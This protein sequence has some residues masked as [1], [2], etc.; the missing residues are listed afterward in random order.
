MPDEP[1]ARAGLNCSNLLRANPE[2]RDLPLNEEPYR[3]A[4][5]MAAFLDGVP[6][7]PKM[8][9]CGVVLSCQPMH[10]LDADI[11]QQGYPTT[12][13]DMDAV[14]D[15]G[16]VKMEPGVGRL[17]AMRDVRAADARIEVDLD[18]IRGITV[19]LG[20]MQAS[21]PWGPSSVGHDRQRWCAGGPSH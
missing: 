2:T 16:L 12:H 3:T 11:H 18:A 13:Y 4:V 8:H 1:A 7:Y 6:R 15:I 10:E 9:P 14:E 19:E 17:A 20:S 5:E 21:E